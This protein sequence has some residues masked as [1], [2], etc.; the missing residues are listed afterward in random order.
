MDASTLQRAT[1]AFFTTKPVGKGTGLGLAT[2]RDIVEQSEGALWIDSAPGAG[3]SVWIALPLTAG[4]TTAFDE[5]REPATSKRAG[6]ILLVED[7]GGVRHITQRILEE[8]GY[9]VRV[10][11]D[12]Q[13]GLR[14][15]RECA[16]QHRT[17]IDCVITDV[18]MPRLSGRTM[19]K[20]MRAIDGSLPVL[21]VSGYVEGGLSE[22]E[23]TGRTSFLAKPFTS[24]ALLMEV[25]ALIGHE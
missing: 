9:V 2:V 6:T 17:P 21:F 16:V 24:E 3:T 18:V 8:A 15:W 19:V 14:C 13:D 12:G 22:E 23:L 20:E 7:E 1:E 25:A 11:S 5:P 10:A 4:G